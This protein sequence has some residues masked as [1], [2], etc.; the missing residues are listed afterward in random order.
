VPDRPYVEIAGRRIG[1]GEPTYIVA[2]MSANHGN[3]YDR[4]ER[5]VRAAKDSGA[6]AIKL[7][8][9]TPDT[10]TIDC[11]RDEFLIKDT[12]WAGQTLYDLY[13]DAAMPWEWQPA[14]ITL[15]RNV[16]LQAF[17]TPFDE[18]AVDFL[19]TLDVPA[20]KIASFEIV[21]LPLLRKVASTSKPVI[22]STGMASLAEIEEAV[23]TLRKG[24][25]R[26]LIL[27]KC[28]SA[29]PASPSEM[30]L[31]SIAHLSSAFN[32][33]AGLSDHSRGIVAAVSAVALG[34]CFIEKHFTTSRSDPGPDASFSMEPGEFRAMV[35]AVR[36]AELARGNIQFGAR[37][38]EMGS[39]PF[40]RSLF[41]IRSM[42][43]GDVFSHENVR[44]IRPAHGLHPRYLDSVIG[45][46]AVVPIERGTPL[47]WDLIG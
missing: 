31:R 36:A 19:E 42:E 8:T 3:D 29:Y 2:E 6:D 13:D 24:G 18:S 45:R 11:H 32:T 17:S 15:A 30:N 26:Q 5:I 43:K 23:Q 9:Y 37:S 25:C 44:S 16:G 33:P 38:A 46:T 21:D 41:V 27:L 35:E 22:L 10:L 20:Y 28:T 4:A 47:S 34:A 39:K 1:P 40:R 14:L 12:I 7:Q